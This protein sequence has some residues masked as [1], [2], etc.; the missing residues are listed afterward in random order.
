MEMTSNL[1]SYRAVKFHNA[2]SQGQIGL[3]I[4][5]GGG[6]LTMH[7]Y[8][9]QMIKCNHKI[10]N[11]WNQIWMQMHRGEMFKIINACQ[12]TI[13]IGSPKSILGQKPMFLYIKS[14]V[15]TRCGHGGCRRKVS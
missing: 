13:G 14:K 3:C 11:Y 7:I 15:S 4:L 8:S 10:W 12:L 5:F 9:Q 1:P 2:I 6:G